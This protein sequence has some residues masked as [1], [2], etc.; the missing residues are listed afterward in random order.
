M[1][2]SQ[3]LGWTLAAALVVSGSVL[4]HRGSAALEATYEVKYNAEAAIIATRDIVEETKNK[5]AP[6]ELKRLRM[7]QTT[8][9]GHALLLGGIVLIGLGGLAAHRQLIG[10]KGAV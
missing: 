5:L 4:C 9:R 2:G 1:S 6:G 10:V 7:Q 8:S 3:F